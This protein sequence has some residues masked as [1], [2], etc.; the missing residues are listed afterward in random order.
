M[1]KKCVNQ[2]LNMPGSEEG[3]VAEVWKDGEIFLEIF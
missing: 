3:R 1:K 2:K